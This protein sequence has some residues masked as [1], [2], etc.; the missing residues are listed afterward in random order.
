LQGGDVESYLDEQAGILREQHNKLQAGDTTFDIARLIKTSTTKEFTLGSL[1]RFYSEDYGLILARYVRFSDMVEDQLNP[2][3]VGRL[4][5]SESVDWVVTNDFAKSGRELAMGIGFFEGIP[6]SGSYGWVVTHGPN[7]FPLIAETEVIPNQNSSYSWTSTGKVGLASRGNV[8]CRRWGQ[9]FGYGIGAGTVFIALEQLSPAELVWAIQQE[10]AEEVQRITTLEG[11]V[12]TTETLIANQGTLITGQATSLATLEARI[13]REEATRS[14]ENQALRNLL[15]TGV[16]VDAAILAGIN[17]VRAEFASAD[18]AIRVTATEAL[19]I[20]NQALSFSSGLD[21]SSINASLDALTAQIASIIVRLS[22]VTFNLT[23]MTANQILKAVV[24]GTDSLGNSI[25]EFQPVTPSLDFLSDVDTT[26]TPPTGGQALIWN[27][28]GSKW[29]PGD[30][31][32]GGGGGSGSGGSYAGVLVARKT[33]DQTITTGA[34]RDVT[35]GVETYDNLNSFTAGGSDFT[36]PAGVTHM[37]VSVRVNWQNTGT[38][39]RYLQLYNVTTAATEALE[40]RSALNE[41]GQTMYT[42]IIPVTAGH[43]YRIQANSGANT[44]TLAGTT[45]G[46]ASVLTVKYLSDIAAL[47]AGVG[48]GYKLVNQAGV[49]IT[50]GATWTY[51]AP[52]VNVDITGLGAYSDFIVV[53]RGIACTANGRRVVLCSVNNG[54]S[55]YSASGDYIYVDTA[56]V[57]TATTDVGGHNTFATAARSFIV[58][59][60]GF[61]VAGGPKAATSNIAQYR[62]FVA[63]PDPVNALRVYNNVAGNLTSGNV[64]V[65][66]R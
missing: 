42:G 21:G 6:A 14:R 18:D 24:T 3:P 15:G 23:G 51:S 45:F 9:A 54:A 32:S 53:G 47:V 22:G 48:N 58:H 29:I 52:I 61:G 39:G 13:A 19:R 50:S 34:W 62:M 49:P 16:D 46:G 5:S 2:A 25:F 11:R 60:H 63:S 43:V 65:F 55:F 17:L 38:S 27:S 4:A 41:A 56:G 8:V 1:G 30:V 10:M 26:T 36:V 66:A 20:A 35:W 7:P 37:E 33:A 28:A 12:T 31:A 59:M 57:E 40:V 64:Y 44:L